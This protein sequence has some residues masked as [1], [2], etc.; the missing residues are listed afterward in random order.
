[1]QHTPYMYV[2]DRAVSDTYNMHGPTIV[3]GFCILHT[4]YQIQNKIHW[5]FVYG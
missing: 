2:E 5:M 4:N 3:F 1:M